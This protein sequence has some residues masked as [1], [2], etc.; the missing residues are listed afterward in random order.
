M[1]I[2]TVVQDSTSTAN[3]ETARRMPREKSIIFSCL[4]KLSREGA[5][6]IDSGRPFH[7]TGRALLNARSPQQH[8]VRGTANCLQSADLRGRDG[9]YNRRCIGLYYTGNNILS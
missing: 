8:S 6:R 3:N 1:C 9:A 2:K 4:L 5:F 7:S